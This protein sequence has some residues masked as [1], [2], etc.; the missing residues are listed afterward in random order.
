LKPRDDEWD[1]AWRNLPKEQRHRIARAVT[2][3]EAVSDPRD[4]QLALEFIDKREQQLQ[5]GR[6]RWFARFL[7][8]RHVVILVCFAVVGIV[9]TRDY[10]VIGI[11]LLAALNLVAVQTFLRRTEKKLVEARRNN[12]QLAEL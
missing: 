2:K 8:R 1:R 3:G 7:T 12:E 5:V 6:S 4:A 10:L 11:A 9:V